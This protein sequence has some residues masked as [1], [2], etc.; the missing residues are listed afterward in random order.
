VKRIERTIHTRGYEMD[1]SGAIPVSVLASY[2]E[3]VRWESVGEPDYPLRDYWR[4]G[5]MRAQRLEVFEDVRFALELNI[6]CWLA[7][8]GRTSLDLAHRVSRADTGALVALAVVTAINLGAEGRP[9][10]LAEGL[11]ALLAD[12]P[13]PSVEALAESAPSDAFV[14]RFEV[15]PSDQDVLQHVNHARYL[16]FV[17]DTRFFGAR[18]GGYKARSE[19][20]LKRAKNVAISYEREASA[21]TLLEARSWALASDP[22]GFGCEIHR[23]EDGQLIARA[24]V[25]VAA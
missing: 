8:V 22:L 5:V 3:H 2:M 1:A 14:R 6:E 17:E 19:Q 23:A 4:R 7:R 24:R 18:A 12:G 15:S 25:G 11:S 16:D 9:E 13:Q 20:A 21:G 10:P